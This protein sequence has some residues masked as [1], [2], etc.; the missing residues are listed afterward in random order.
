M[1]INK[2]FSPPL[3]FVACMVMAVFFNVA[4]AQNND[5]WLSM[6]PSKSIDKSKKIVLIAGDEEYRSEESLP[7]LAKILTHHHGFH[8]VVLFPINPKTKLIDPAYQQNIPGLEAL[9]DADLVVF[10][11]RFRQLPDDQ[12]QWID[13]YLKAGKPVIGL[14]TATHGFNFPADVKSAYAHY[15]YNTAKGPWEG[16]FGRL[17][18]GETWID[19]HGD[20]GTEGTR[21]I[22]NGIEQ[23][24]GNPLLR[25]VNDV[26]VPSDV[27]GIRNRSS[28]IKVLLYGQPTL[29]MDAT[30][31]INQKKSIM[32]VA[33]TKEYQ[34]PEGKKGKA[35]TTT[36]GSAVDFLN[37]D[38]RR[39]FV[40]ACY[41]GLG[42][43]GS[44][45]EEA[46]VDFLHPFTP[47]MFGFG[48]YIKGK[49]PQDYQ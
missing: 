49:V 46:K 11:T 37:E 39:L 44:I 12:M 8:T 20:H 30:A 18:L 13:S 4:C 48:T 3:F 14:R 33:W 22:N 40:N 21:A 29:G 42:L 16:G 31:A 41:W 5:L 38:L 26:W 10:A 1:R 35:F 6:K 17:V 25:G 23:A 28:D 19:H 32:P 34:I 7:M 15:S 47:T 27:Y 24:A 43:E 45:P 36:M 9:K 2:S